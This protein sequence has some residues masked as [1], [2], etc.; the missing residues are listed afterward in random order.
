MVVVG[1]DGAAGLVVVVVDG[2]VP[3]VEPGRPWQA[4][5]PASVKVLPA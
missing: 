2:D 3:P 5:V 4:A 1:V